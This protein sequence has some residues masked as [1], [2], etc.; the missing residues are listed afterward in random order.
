MPRSFADQAEEPVPEGVTL[1][2]VAPLQPVD[3]DERDDHRLSAGPV[4][5]VAELVVTRI[6]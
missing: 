2:V 4:H 3:V 6:A 5:G 1:G